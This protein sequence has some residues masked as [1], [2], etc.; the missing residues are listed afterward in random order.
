MRVK[1]S[2]QATGRR[3]PRAAL[4][5]AAV[6]SR[7]KP[8]AAHPNS[9]PAMTAQTTRLTLICMAGTAYWTTLPR[10]AQATTAP[11][12]QVASA[13]TTAGQENVPHRTSSTKSA[14][15]SGTL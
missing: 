15:P 14:A 13:M 5:R 12:Q 7:W 8:W 9:G 2:R 4:R 6:V 1:F 3:H 11:M 10:P